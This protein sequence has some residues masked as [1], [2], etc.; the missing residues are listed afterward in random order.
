[1]RDAIPPDREADR[2]A[3]KREPL[4]SR[5]IGKIGKMEK[6]KFF[7][8]PNSAIIERHIWK[9]FDNNPIRRKP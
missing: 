3:S 8:K 2:R 5:D 7:L 6:K 4:E 9:E 1:M